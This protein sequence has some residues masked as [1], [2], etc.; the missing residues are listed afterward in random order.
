MNRA[1]E[2]PPLAF[3]AESQSLSWAA[4]SIYS[5]AGCGTLLEKTMKC[6]PV[7]VLACLLAAMPAAA[8]DAAVLWNSVANPQFD[9]AK[10][11]GVK[12]LTIE[13]DRL[14]I[15]LADGTIQFTQ[16]VAGRVFAAAFQGHGR[17]QIAP[18]NEREAQQLRLLTKQDGLGEDFTEA[19]FNFS[20][21]TYEEV[22]QKLQWNA[23]AA[24]DLGGM[25]TKRQQ[26]RDNLGLS[27]VPRI[28][29]GLLSADHQRTAYFL[30]DVKTKD[31]WVE[32]VVDALDPE[33]IQAGHWVET[34]FYRGFETWLSFPAGGGTAGEAFNDP[35]AKADFVVS[36][37]K[38]DARV[39]TGAELS[40]TAQVFLKHRAGGERLLLFELSPNLRVDSVKDGSGGVLPFFQPRDPKDRQISYGDY[41]AVL[42]SQPSQAGTSQTIEFHYAGKRAIRQEGPG[43]YF[44]QSYGWYPAPNQT[45]LALA[46]RSNFELKFRNPKKFILVATG[47]RQSQT[48]EGNEVLTTWKSDIPLAVAGFAFGDYKVDEQKVGNIDLQIYANRDPDKFLTGMNEI[49]HPNT[50]GSDEGNMIPLGQL[51][52]V[53]T[54]K[55]MGVEF[56]NTLKLFQDYFGP[57][58]YS[59]LAV[60]NIPYSYGQG[61]PGLLYISVLSFLDQTQRHALG[62]QDQIGISDF[63]RAHETSHQWWGHQVGCK[64]YHDQWMSE[65]FA[66]FSGNLYVQF[67]DS[68]GEYLRAC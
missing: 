36:D 65:G 37:Y 33:E 15:T 39:T 54:I 23:S 10:T 27:D 64:S 57:Y 43:N 40:A 20:D 25:Y 2:L 3:A 68:P 12:D 46:T 66:Q 34:Q 1:F 62:I 45:G 61:W 11:A 31:G 60:T 26:E 24:A 6:S 53:G 16:P 9:A 32:A 35:L 58:P 8:Q 18:P 51:D 48:T 55:T 49:L 59:H 17:L 50:P 4:Y 56:G 13:R 38:I 19:I 44:C 29:K 22:A 30:A 47:T 67:R 14:H 21:G 52:A 5:L 7:L 28:L 63:F 41:V 42:L